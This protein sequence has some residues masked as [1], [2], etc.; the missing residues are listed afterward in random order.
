MEPQA[1]RQHLE[2]A[3][4]QAAPGVPLSFRAMFGGLAAYAYGQVFASLSD[5]GLALKLP[6]QA[7]AAL[8]EE[9]GARRLQYDPGSPPSKQYV[10]VPEGFLARPEALVPWVKASLEHV[11]SPPP[12]ARRR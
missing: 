4:K 10:V 8:L 5:V 3:V 11:A 7:Q 2:E 6:A 1:L 12:K 9:A